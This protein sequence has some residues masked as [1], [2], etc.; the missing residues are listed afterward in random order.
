MS[1]GNLTFTNRGLNLLS[2]GQSGTPIQITKIKVG[3]GQLGSSS[4]LD[5][6][7]LKNAVAELNIERKQVMPSNQILI[8]AV[9]RNQDY[10][11]GFY[12]REFGIM[13]ND[14]ELG[15]ILYAYVNAGTLADYIPAPSSAQV[16]KELEAVLQFGNASNVTITVNSLGMISKDMIDK[17]S[18]VAGIGADGKIKLE[19]IPTAELNADKVDGYHVD[20]TKSGAN[21]ENNSLWTAKK[22]KEITDGLGSQIGQKLDKTKVISLGNNKIMQLG[23]MTN[24]NR[25]GLYA[26]IMRPN[27]GFTS[28]LSYADLFLG[29]VSG[30]LVSGKLQFNIDLSLAEHKL[31]IVLTDKGILYAI[32]PLYNNSRWIVIENINFAEDIQEVSAIDGNIVWD[33]DNNTTKIALQQTP[34]ETIITSGFASG[35]TGVLAYRKN[36]EGYVEISWNLTKSTDITS[37]NEAVYT[38]PTSVRPVSSTLIPIVFVNLLTTPGNVTLFNSEAYVQ[39]RT[40]GVF[41]IGAVVGAVTTNARKSIGKLS[42]YVGI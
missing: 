10:T 14:P 8:S 2:K 3:D 35:W 27:L 9:L 36:Q 15:E 40:T 23:I 1:F 29:K 4:I 31:R 7:D 19:F 17:S 13:A 18:G 30:Y 20:D 6:N 42:Y 41:E 39:V 33:S 25:Y 28:E 21:E 37:S 24:L 16:V 12:L 34:T 22:V 11:S 5:L 26:K 32:S 38:L